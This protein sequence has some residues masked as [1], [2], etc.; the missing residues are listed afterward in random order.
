LAELS[1]QRAV[2]ELIVINDEDSWGG[3]DGG[4]RGGGK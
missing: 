3:A 1:L 4:H 2:E